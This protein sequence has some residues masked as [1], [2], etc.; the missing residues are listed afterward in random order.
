MD[1]SGEPSDVC[2]AKFD[3]TRLETALRYDGWREN[4]GVLFD[5]ATRDGSKPRVS[6][7]ASIVTADLGDT[8]LARARAESQLFRRSPKRVRTEE[9]GL[10]LVQYFPRGGGV[11]CGRERLVAGDMQIVDTEKPYELAATDYENLTLMVPHDLR[12]TISPVIDKLH[13]RRLP[14]K[15]PMVRMLGEHL[16]SLWDNVTSMSVSQARKAVRGTIG[17]I[18]GY[19]DTDTGLAGDLDPAVGDAL[20]LAMRRFIEQNLQEP[21]DVDD[22]ARQFRVSRSQV[23]RLFKRHEGVAR[24]VWERRL[25]RSRTLLTAPWLQHLSIGAVAFEVG[26]SSNAHFSRAFR[27]RF[28]MTPRQMR[29]EVRERS[30]GRDDRRTS[31][32]GISIL[33][34]DMV[35]SLAAN[36]TADLTVSS[37]G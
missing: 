7:P 25:Q 11:I 24:Y 35:R 18:H 1:H 6:K 14:G 33:I 28:G 9:L 8:V 3:S 34:P 37:S 23:Y 5:V 17:L 16:Q 30:S 13:G 10:I 19:F 27:A 22:F 21:L 26:Y 2:I 29:T 4:M 12:A 31:E 20:D 15:D 32:A 36:A